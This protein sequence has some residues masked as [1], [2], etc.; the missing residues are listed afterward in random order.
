MT[1][2]FSRLE[3][4]AIELNLE[5]RLSKLIAND[6]ILV[7]INNI[8]RMLSYINSGQF[9]VVSK[10]RWTSPTSSVLVAVKQ[11]SSTAST[12]DR[13]KLL[14]EGAIMGQFQHKHIVKLYGLITITNPVRLQPRLFYSILRMQQKLI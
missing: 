2:L 11:I 3:K 4:I 9:G 5:R 7:S 13:L 1:S 10:A 14:Q 12:T 8:Y 6:K